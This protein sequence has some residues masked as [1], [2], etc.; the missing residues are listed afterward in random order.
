MIVSYPY[1]QY[2]PRIS[3]VVTRTDDITVDTPYVVSV[4]EDTMFCVS[5]KVEI[6][7]SVIVVTIFPIADGAMVSATVDTTVSVTV[8]LPVEV[9]ISVTVATTV[10]TTVSVTVSVSVSVTVSVAV[11][12]TTAGVGVA[13]SGH[14]LWDQVTVAVWTIT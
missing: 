12:V 10:E 1:Q 6:N 4:T 7:C 9:T 8:S 11:S 14:R 13:I 3:V 5:V 2:I